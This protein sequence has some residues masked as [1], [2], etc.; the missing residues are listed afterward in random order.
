MGEG[1]KFLN[2]KYMFSTLY[3]AREYKGSSVAVKELHDE[4]Q[5]LKESNIMVGLVHP[6]IINIITCHGRFIVM[7]LMTGGCIADV[8]EDERHFSVHES[9][10]L[11]LQVLAAVQYLHERSPM[12]VHRDIKN[13]NLLLNESR[14]VVKLGDFGLAKV[15]SKG[16]SII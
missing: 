8:I 15:S 16:M 1:K 2:S 7:D 5:V 12:I 9:M 4:V 14:S 11:I 3:R 13:E 10:N 6:N